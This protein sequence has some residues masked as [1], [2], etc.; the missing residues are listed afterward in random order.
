MYSPRARSEVAHVLWDFESAGG[1]VVVAMDDVQRTKS[2]CPRL[3]LP[4]VYAGCPILFGGGE[5][6]T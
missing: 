2:L 5:A 4:G 1:T 3:L 6:S